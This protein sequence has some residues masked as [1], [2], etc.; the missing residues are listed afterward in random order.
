MRHLSKSILTF[1]FFSNL[2]FTA[3]KKNKNPEPDPIV[4]AT[5]NTAGAP[6]IYLTKPTDNF[7]ISNS[8]GSLFVDA[9]ITDDDG[10][11]SL[12]YG[13][14][15]PSANYNYISNDSVS[16]LGSGKSLPFQ[17]N[18]V[19][20]DDENVSIGPGK[21]DFYVKDI[22]GLK[23]T[24]ITRNFTITD[25]IDFSENRL[26]DSIFSND[27]LEFSIHR[28]NHN[29]VDSILIYNITRSSIV[30]TVK[31]T[32]GIKTLIVY[33]SNGEYWQFGMTTDLT[34]LNVIK[35]GYKVQLTQAGVG[36]GVGKAFITFL[37][38]EYD[39]SST[40]FFTG[41]TSYYSTISSLECSCNS[42]EKIVI[43]IKE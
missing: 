23:S 8:S 35:V 13:L 41:S 27:S 40:N 12:H 5:G 2:L 4:V 22:T 17:R 28:N 36:G 19:L 18:V 6:V 7:S 9:L 42:L 43:P 14:S 26:M 33:E 32:G 37:L 34:D 25:D 16:I 21:I 38:R 11:S 30:S 24:T 3:C 39:S 31:D 1:I 20:I 15:T 29:I 10:L